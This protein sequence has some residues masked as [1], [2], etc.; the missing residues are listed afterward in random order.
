M[1]SKKGIFPPCLGTGNIK[2]GETIKFITKCYGLH[3]MSDMA[4]ARYNVWLN[5]TKSKSKTIL[6][7]DLLPNENC[8]KENV[9]RAEYQAAVWRAALHDTL[10][11][12][13]QKEHGWIKNDESK[14]LIPC[15]SSEKML[16]M[17][18]KLENLLSCSCSGDSPCSKGQC[19]CKKMCL[20]CTIFCQCHQV[21]CSSQFTK[22]DAIF[23]DADE[24]NSD[25]VSPSDADD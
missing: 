13:D 10:P 7:E 15:F 23:E 22:D 3:D 16:V 18:E 11:S 24:D 1:L 25:E 5:K 6:L 9:K 4:S 12:L 19:G 8:L 20:P 21:G 14:S 17:P 2:F